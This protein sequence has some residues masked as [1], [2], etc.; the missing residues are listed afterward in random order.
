MRFLAPLLVMSL[1]FVPARADALTLR[2]IVE[3]HRAG[4]SD[5]VIVALVEVRNAVFTLD[6]ETMKALKAD[7]LSD[8][9]LIAIINSGR[10]PPPQPLPVAIEPESEP[11]A[12]VI[13]VDHHEHAPAQPQVIVQ[14]VPVYIPVPVPHSRRVYGDL[15]RTPASPFYTGQVR[16][17]PA[18]A[19]EPVYWGFGGKLR[20]DAWQPAPTPDRGKDRRGQDRTGGGK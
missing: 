3:L 2:D 14:Q 7:G 19:P 16:E 17:A 10:T 13:L 11:V 9:V 1:S 5:D 15:P 12:R 4:L 20:P 18:K 6:Q 8:R